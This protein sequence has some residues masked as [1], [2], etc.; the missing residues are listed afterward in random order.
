MN[1]LL[2]KYL[3]YFNKLN[4]GFNPGFGKAPHKPILLLSI[5][6]IVEKGLLNTNRLFITP[7]LVLRFKEYFVA[8]VDTGHHDN[9]ALPFFHMKSEPFYRLIPRMGSEKKF[10]K[11]RSVKSISK[12]IELIAFAEIDNELFE[13]L[14]V[15]SYRIIIKKVL[16]DSYFPGHEL[17][18]N[19]NVQG[20]LETL[21]EQEILNES[22]TEYVLRLKSIKAKLEEADFEEELF[23]RGG[24]FKK[25]IPKIYDYTCCISGFKIISNHN[26]QMVDACHIIPFS[27]SQDDTISN[28]LSLSPTLHRAFD[29]GLITIDLDFKVQVSSSIIKSESTRELLDLNGSPIKLPRNERY[30]PSSEALKWHNCEVFLR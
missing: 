26:F 23:V 24:V 30:N 19:A 5:I 13:L 29:R 11:L 22:S 9:F 14:Q 4:R 27:H 28:G 7:E 18:L 2:P 21:I 1:Q 25:T 3:D 20:Y 8:L 15:Q 10:H 16:L 6:D 12:L 17:N